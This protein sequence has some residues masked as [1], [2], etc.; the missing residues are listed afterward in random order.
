MAAMGDRWA[1]LTTCA[2]RR[3][4]PGL[5]DPDALGLVFSLAYLTAGLLAARVAFGR[6]PAQR[7]ERWLWGLAAALLLV[8]AVNKQLDLQVFVTATLRCVARAEGW[9]GAR[10]GLQ[11]EATLALIVLAAV[12]LPALAF[13][14]RKV[15]RR[16]LLLLT[17]TVLLVVFV[18][19]RAISFHHLDQFLHT[20]VLS[21]RLHRLIE[22]AAL[23]LILLAGL[24]R[25]RQ[26]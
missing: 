25:L 18:L 6:R 2:A 7:R 5:G 26:R 21:V 3:W 23:G 14:F 4:A 9:Y 15:L 1:I 10:R 20:D 22:G 24:M 8:L 16:N 19:I 17:G 13:V 12:A 11:A